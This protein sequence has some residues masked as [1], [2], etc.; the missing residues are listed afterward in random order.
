MNSEHPTNMMVFQ[1][2]GSAARWFYVIMGIY[3]LGAAFFSLHGSSI[4]AYSLYYPSANDPMIGTCKHRISFISCSATVS[5]LSRED[6]WVLGAPR[7]FGIFRS[8]T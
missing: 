1:R 2:D 5:C 3:V 7:F 8:N 4:D 6:R